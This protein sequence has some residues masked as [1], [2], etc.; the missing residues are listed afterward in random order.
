MNWEKVPYEN[1]T[2]SI[3]KMQSGADKLLKYGMATFMQYAEESGLSYCDINRIIST[4][5]ISSGASDL[6]EIPCPPE[7]RQRRFNHYTKNYR[8]TVKE[9]QKIIKDLDSVYYG[10][11]PIP[12]VSDIASLTRGIG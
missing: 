5:R 4:A 8:Y 6:K 12:E 9:T 2:I 1:F 10:D 11:Q 3:F 7:L